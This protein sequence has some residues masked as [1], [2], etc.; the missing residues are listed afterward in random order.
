[1]KITKTIEKAVSF[2]IGVTANISSNS[3]FLILQHTYLIYE[4]IM[5]ANFLPLL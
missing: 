3:K 2:E 4:L 5:L 1:M